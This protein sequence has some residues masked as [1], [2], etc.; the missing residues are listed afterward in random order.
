MSG[1]NSGIALQESPSEP[2]NNRKGIFSSEP[3][4]PTCEAL[5]VKAPYPVCQPKAWWS[6][7]AARR[8]LIGAISLL[9]GTRSHQP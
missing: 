4:V 3:D 1:Q 7:K 9:D 6:G 5:T 2:K 8:A